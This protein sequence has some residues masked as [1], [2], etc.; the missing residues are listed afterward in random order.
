MKPACS[1]LVVYPREQGGILFLITPEA[2]KAVSN[3]MDRSEC[4]EEISDES[5]VMRDLWKMMNIRYSLKFGI[6]K[7]P[8]KFQIRA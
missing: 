8:I 7:K 2:Y 3:W 4:G 1:K 6:A 5:Y